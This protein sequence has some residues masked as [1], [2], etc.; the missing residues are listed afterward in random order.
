MSGISDRTIIYF[1]KIFNRAIMAL[2]S[3]SLLLV[4][5]FVSGIAAGVF[6]IGGGILIV[7]GL[8][9][10]AGFSQHTATGTSLAILLPPVGLAAVLEYY[11]HG[12]VDLR[13]A[14][15][16]GAALFAG[17]WIG[18]II[19]NNLNGPQLKLAFGIFLVCLGV[20]LV[21]TSWRSLV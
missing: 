12:N 9:Y 2:P 21:G 11:R 5:G 16:V 7:P 10:L 3:I 20:Y 15:V 4:I 19:A 1:A 13:T 18:A 6:G 14:L 17:A 8:V